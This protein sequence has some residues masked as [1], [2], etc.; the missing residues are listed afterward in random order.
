M[1]FVIPVV[2]IGG[3]LVGLVWLHVKLQPQ[4]VERPLKPPKQPWEK[5]YR[6]GA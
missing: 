3:A 5:G 2:V 1:W 6:R 4:K